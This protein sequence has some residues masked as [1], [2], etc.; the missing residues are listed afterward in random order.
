MI[1]TLL[2]K[3]LRRAGRNPLPW[4]VYLIIPLCITAMLGLTFGNRSEKNLLGQ[5][6]FALVDEDQSRLTQLLSRALGHGFTNESLTVVSLDRAAAEREIRASHLGGA[7]VIPPHF[8]RDY[9]LSNQPVSLEL[10]KNPA[11]SIHPAVLEEAGGMVVAVLN[12]LDRNFQ[13]DFTEWRTLI[14]APVEAAQAARLFKET[15]TKLKTFG[16]YLDPPLV[17]YDRSQAPASTAKSGPAF[18]L[19]AYLLAGMAGMFLL[20]EA[21]NGMSDLQQELRLRTFARYQTL[22]AQTLPFLAGKMVFTV[23][24][25]VLCAAIMLGGGALVFHIHWQ[26][27]LVLAGLVLSYA[28]FGAAL[29]AVLVALMPDERQGNVLSTIAAMGLGLAGGCAFPAEQL[30][31]FFREHITCHLPS[32]WFVNT[33]RQLQAGGGDG[34]WQLV[35]LKLLLITGVLTVLASVLFRRRFQLGGQG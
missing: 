20:F 35:I 5:V 12:A 30:P 32:Y 16:Q 23:V 17:S 26:Q 25:L 18:N 21:V 33:V 4:L 15:G 22:H 3:D 6:R 24:L 29:M 14:A 7:V 10:I 13:A 31:V 11:Q 28:G 1:G 8:T 9:F 34:L 2:A 27:P 19:F